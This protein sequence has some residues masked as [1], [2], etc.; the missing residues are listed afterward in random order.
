MSRVLGLKEKISDTEGK[1]LEIQKFQV[2]IT[3]LMHL[4]SGIQDL[5]KGKT[6]NEL[7]RYL[8]ESRY[9]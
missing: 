7:D 3:S 6:Q 2:S 8:Q 4:C 9:F 5:R 1:D